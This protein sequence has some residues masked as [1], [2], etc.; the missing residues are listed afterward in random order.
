MHT[1]R[2]G[3]FFIIGLLAA[4][5]FSTGCASNSGSSYK[6]DEAR[7]AQSVQT[8]TITHIGR[9]TI[10]QDS[11]FLGPII[12]GVVGGVLGS[13]FGAGTGRT[14]AILGGAAGGALAGSMVDK[15]IQTENALEISIQLDNGQI[16]S[17]VQAEDDLYVVGDKVRVVS[18]ANGR[19]RVQH[20]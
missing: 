16:I 6:P 13:T 19:S 18:G 17:V 1:R 20:F 8:G 11:S 10:E 5:T 4:L 9:A 3:F 7:V 2:P 12:G 14:L 15:Q